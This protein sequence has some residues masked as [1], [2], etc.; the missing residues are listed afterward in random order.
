[1]EYDMGWTILGGGAA[2]AVLTVCWGYIRTTWN[3]V[4]GLMVV[5][6]EFTGVAT[7]II[8][9]YCMN[10]LQTSKFG[11]RS[12]FSWTEYIRPRRKTEYIG[13]ESI[14]AE[15]KVYW[16]SWV[17]I[18]LSR[19]SPSGSQ[20]DTTLTQHHPIALTFW[21]GT[22]DI[23]QLFKKAIKKRNR[24]NSNQQERYRIYYITGLAG[25]QTS[26]QYSNG[27]DVAKKEDD[28]R[29][30]RILF[31]KLEDLG[32]HRSEQG[33]LATLALSQEME[34]LVSFISKWREQQDW[35]EACGVPWKM[36]VLLYGPPGTGKTATIRAL[37]EE[38]DY[39]VYSYDLA[40]LYND[41]LRREWRTML[42]NT[43]CIALFDDI[44]AVFEG[45]ESKHS[46]TFDCFLNCLDGVEKSDGILTFVTTNR[47]ELIDS[48][49][50]Q[51]DHGICTRPGRIDRAIQMGPL[52]EKGRFKLAQRILKDWP[53]YHKKIV[54]DGEGESGAQFQER[55]VIEALQR[56][57]QK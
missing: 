56:I 36:G 42:S 7:E 34:S 21:R 50:V 33:S 24:I 22:L 27:S 16:S 23:E 35:Y 51:L 45:R 37:A 32:P 5:R 18:I 26:A 15:P 43:P 17:P 19:F 4:I 2:I 52:E 55:C 41:E 29:G 3:W 39:P 38:F 49:L 54:A 10:D 6:A 31:W 57:H 9:D 48:A 14:G 53:K 20:M 1:M 46:I 25:K 12:F 44:D 11:T 8:S 30:R 13:A 47:P 40:T 28:R